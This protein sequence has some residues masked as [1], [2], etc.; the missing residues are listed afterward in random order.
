MEQTTIRKNGHCG[1]LAFGVRNP[2]TNTS[3]YLREQGISYQHSCNPNLESFV[4]P[5]EDGDIY[6]IDVLNFLDDRFRMKGV[7][8]YAYGKHQEELETV[9]NGLIVSAGAIPI[10]AGRISEEAG[11]IFAKRL[12]NTLNKYVAAREEKQNGSAG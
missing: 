9:L 11:K 8:G 10:D 1:V 6:N 2:E 5:Y 7:V 12:E 3:E 4:I